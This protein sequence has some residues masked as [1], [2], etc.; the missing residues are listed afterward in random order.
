MAKQQKKNKKKTK[1]SSV[2][3]S[4]AG[5]VK[6]QLHRFNWKLAL[7][8]ALSTLVSFT[9][10][11]ALIAIPSLRIDGIPVIMPIYL[12]IVT[13]LSSLVVIFNSGLSAKPITVDMLRS[14]DGADGNELRRICEKLNARKKIAKKLMI[15]LLPFLFALLFDMLYL[16]YGD[17]FKGA[18]EYISGG[19]SQ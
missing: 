19:T 14:K 10:Y 9:V 7:L 1:T 16:F 13:V 6:T 17:F 15:I 12:I 5:E 18:V 4:P 3:L 11:E 8:I 2:S